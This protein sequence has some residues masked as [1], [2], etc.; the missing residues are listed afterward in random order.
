[1][2]G[3][4]V[5]VAFRGYRL[6]GEP[7]LISFVEPSMSHRRRSSPFVLSLAVAGSLVFAAQVAILSVAAADERS[8]ELAPQVREALSQTIRGILIDSLPEKIEVRDDWG[9]TKSTFSGL[10][11]KLDGLKLKVE[12]R[13]RDRNHGLWKQ[14]DIT[15]IDPAKNLQF[16]IASAT[17]TGPRRFKFQIVTSAP[18]QTVGRIERWRHGTK[19]FNAKLEAAATIEMRLDGELEYDFESR[20]GFFLVLKPRATAADLRLSEFD[21]QRI[22]QLGGDLVHEL[23]DFVRGPLGKQVDGLEPKAVEKMNGAIAKRADKLR[24]AVPSPLDFSGWSI[25]DG[26]AIAPGK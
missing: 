21:W 1:M 7:F 22:G 18:L 25:L 12:K 14:F 26:R 6:R 19:F 20:D 11:W 2:I 3:V 13:E 5:A 16:Q 23:G 9:D 24:I 8:F 15:P 10:T 4:P 17:S